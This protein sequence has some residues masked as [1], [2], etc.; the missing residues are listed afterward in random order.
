[1]ISHREFQRR[2][3]SMRWI[4]LA[5]TFLYF[6][7]LLSVPF[8]IADKVL[9]TWSGFSQQ[10]LDIVKL[11]IILFTPPLFL[12]LILYANWRCGLFCPCCGPKTAHVS[13]DRKS[14]RLNSSHA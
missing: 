8:G 9:A 11:L 3:R 12:L 5:G 4:V 2:A 1:M 10:T 7:W 14:T 13:L 6:A